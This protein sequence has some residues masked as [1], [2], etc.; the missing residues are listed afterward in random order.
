MSE[1]DASTSAVW[2]K[3]DRLRQLLQ[4]GKKTDRMSQIQ[5]L[6]SGRKTSERFQAFGDHVDRLCQE[7]MST[8]GNART[9][10]CFSLFRI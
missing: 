2:Q 8:A 3:T 9:P 5:L 1:G 10:G 6:Q 7:D 4:S